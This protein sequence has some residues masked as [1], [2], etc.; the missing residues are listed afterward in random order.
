MASRR[1]LPD[2]VVLANFLGEV[3]DVATF[4]FTTLKPVYCYGGQGASVDNTGR[5]KDDSANLYIFDLQSKAY[6]E[7]GGER[8]YLDYTL[9][10]ALPDKSGFWTL[11][12]GG[13][14]YFRKI[15]LPGREFRVISFQKLKAG[16]PR[17]WHFEV[18]GR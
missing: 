16:T 4:Q 1:M 11:Y 14:D 3:D 13:R 15:G 12:D 5:R 10:K 8:Q 7:D 18:I 6:G 17:M 9:W 2:E